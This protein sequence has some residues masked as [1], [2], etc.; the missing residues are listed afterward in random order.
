MGTIFVSLVQRF[1]VDIFLLRTQND[2]VLEE[3]TMQECS[4]R[5]IY[6]S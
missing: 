6:F 5:V 1:C 2:I 3:D 4:M